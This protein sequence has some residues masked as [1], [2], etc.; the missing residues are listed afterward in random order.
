MLLRRLARE[1]RDAWRSL[2]SGGVEKYKRTV[3]R[4]RVWW[5]VVSG[6]DETEILGE[7]KRVEK[8]GVRL[9]VAIKTGRDGKQSV[10]MQ[11]QRSTLDPE[12]LVAYT[13]LLA[14]TVDMAAYQNGTSV[15]AEQ[16]EDL[17]LLRSDEPVDRFFAMLDF[18]YQENTELNL[19][20]KATLLAHLTHFTSSTNS[21]QTEPLLPPPEPKRPRQAIDPFY[22]LRTCTE[23][24]HAGSRKNMLQFMERYDR[25]SGY[26]PTKEKKLFSMLR[27]EEERP[28]KVGRGREEGI[29][30][31]KVRSSVRSCEI[32][33]CFEDEDEKAVSEA[34]AAE[35]EE[36]VE[37]WLKALDDK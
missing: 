11:G 14:H 24:V 21:S 23:S 10:V 6:M 20:S 34:E 7:V 30:A 19:T 13:E 16:L 22:R 3:D 35:R 27:A 29:L 32:G 2:G 37:E 26:M 4:E 5:D 9:A 17:Q 33:R 25:A 1:K 8:C 36:R 18:L 12:F 31:A 15:L 28:R